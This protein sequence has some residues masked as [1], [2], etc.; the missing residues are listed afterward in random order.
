M[1][2]ARARRR[3]RG[4]TVPVAVLAGLAPIVI[5]AV[6]PALTYGLDANSLREGANRLTMGFTGYDPR[7]KTWGHWD[8]L[9]KGLGLTLLGVGAH[10]LAGKWG[11]NRAIAQAGIPFIR[12]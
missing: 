10:K 4:F 3:A 6:E 11:I 12:I 1:A 8:Y 2:K 5:D 7:T 9:M